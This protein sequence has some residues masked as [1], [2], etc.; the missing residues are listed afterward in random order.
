MYRAVKRVII[1]GG[2]SAG[3]LTAGVLASRF[4]TE[5]QAGLEVV[6]VESPDVATIG[7]GEGTWPS[8]RTTLQN[9]GVSETDF[10]R[11]CDASLKQGSRFENWVTGENDHYYHPFSLPQGF[12][13]FNLVPHWQQVRD[14]ISFADAVCQQ[15]QVC[16]RGLAAKTISTPEYA[17]NVNYGYHLDAG[18]FA[19]FLQRHCVDKLGVQHVLDHVTTV[20]SRPNGDIESLSTADSGLIHGDL[21]I[22]CTG[23]ASVLIGQHYD[24]PFKSVRDVLFNDTALA[25]Q[26]PYRDS[27]D[28]IASHTL[29][30]AQSAGWIWNIGLPTRRGVGHVYSS[31]Y[32]SDEN[33]E[34]ELRNYLEPIVGRHKSEEL[35]VRKIAI[36]P[37]YRQE[38]WHRN[39]VAVGL[40]AG[41]V[42]PLEAS[43]LVL[44]EYSAKMIAEQ[45]PANRDIMN[46]AAKRFNEKFHYRWKQIIDFLK[47][48]YVLNRQDDQGYW[49]AHRTSDSVPES[50]QESVNLW[51]HQSP[52][53]Q[54]APHFDE[55]FSSASFQFVLCGM[56]FVSRD[57]AVSLRAD[58]DNL[59]RANKLF[60][61]NAKRTAHLLS[62]LPSNRELINKV[63]E[64]GFQKI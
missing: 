14:K 36:N 61:E 63:L 13:E 21:F 20:N 44:V 60:G 39:C 24:V 23:F 32:I 15:S 56:G 10:I 25:A 52:W 11:E 42:E 35:S 47:L 41:F 40:S 29:A 19:G 18:K 49:V 59:A 5:A 17:F 26:V 57:N 54:D 50:L 6:L 38:F 37:G 28:P 31:K 16:D 46:I 34:R 33:A 4:D 7:V 53:L 22:D 55:L 62:S 3:W 58:E 9:M 27:N 51:Q 64:F 8:M 30:T 48:H 43:A 45:L 1:V 12:G 2:G